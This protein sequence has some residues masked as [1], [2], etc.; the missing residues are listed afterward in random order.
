MSS[1]GILFYLLIGNNLAI[2]AHN[3]NVLIIVNDINTK[4]IGRI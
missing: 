1:N 4:P 3:N 2:F